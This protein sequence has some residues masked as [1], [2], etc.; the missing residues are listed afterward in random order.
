VNVLA[1]LVAI[2]KDR[3]AELRRVGTPTPPTQLRRGFAEALRG[4]ARTSVIA[5]FKRSSP[6][7]DA[8]APDMELR[9]QVERYADAG[10]AAISVLTEPSRFGG[11]PEDLQEAAGWVQVPLLMKDF[12]VDPIQVELA[13]AMGA[14]AVLLIA[15]CLEPGQLRE[16]GAAATALGLDV[17]VECHDAAEIDRALEI[18]QAVIGVNNRDLDTLTIDRNRALE[19]LPR[20]P[21]QRIVVAESG[22]D[23]PEQIAPL[24]GLADAVL[25]GT[26]L[27]RSQ[28]P[29]TFIRAV[30][31]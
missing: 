14:S 2:S 24:R 13:R 22:Y 25:V 3:A 20:V 30:S 31:R 10:A 5:E 15:R 1:E 8:I 26:A 16:L 19:L 23:D 28:D 7:E 21:E 12:L 17:L 29:S 18:E 4:K 6:S 27:M 9:A 11:R